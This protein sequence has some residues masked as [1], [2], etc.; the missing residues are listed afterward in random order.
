MAAWPLQRWNTP[1]ICLLIVGFG[2]LT[3]VVLLLVAAGTVTGAC[4]DDLAFTG[5]NTTVSIVHQQTT[6]AVVITYQK[7]EPLTPERTEELFVTIHAADGDNTTSYSL[8][9]TPEAFPVSSGDRFTIRNATV[10]GR[11][12]AAGD[13]IRVVWRGSENPLPSY[14]LTTRGPGSTSMVLKLHIIE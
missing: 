12:L 10:G 7:G 3:L 11:L 13:V 4:D 9:G 8:T 1:R 14:C 2:C 6:N 5:P